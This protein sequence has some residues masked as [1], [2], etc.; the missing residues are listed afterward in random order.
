MG[1]PVSGSGVF[2]IKIFSGL[3]SLW[4]MSILIC[5]EEEK[6][7]ERGVP[8]EMIQSTCNLLEDWSSF[9]FGEEFP[10]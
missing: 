6:E 7:R 9:L 2:K 4:M 10:F 1:R 8:V 5:C 3:I